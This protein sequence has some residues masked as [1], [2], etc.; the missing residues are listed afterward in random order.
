M[1][2]LPIV[3]KNLPKFVVASVDKVNKRM[4]P[5]KVLRKERMIDLEKT[6]LSTPRLDVGSWIYMDM[7]EKYIGIQTTWKVKHDC[8]NPTKPHT[9]IFTYRPWKY[10]LSPLNPPQ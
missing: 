9:L 5:Y 4:A 2:R 10:S 8:T 7:A 1:K 6:Q 3:K